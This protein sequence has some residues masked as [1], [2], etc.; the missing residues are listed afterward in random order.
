MPIQSCQINNEPGYKWGRQGK[1]YS[2]TPGDEASKNSA[3]KSAIAQGVVIGDLEALA[4]NI[5]VIRGTYDLSVEVEELVG[6]KV[7][8]DYDG[9]L[10]TRR[11][12]DKLLATNADIYIITARS[13][14]NMYQVY[15]VAKELRI[16][17]NRV[18]STGSNR[19]KIDKIREL[20]IRTHYDNNPDVIKEL[21]GVGRLF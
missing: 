20:G 4:A 16:P 8:F 6:G 1:C 13:M 10:S 9:V 3:K 21:P 2:Y 12:K 5:G 17:R 14:A 11:G 18:I 7:S 15:Q 19:A